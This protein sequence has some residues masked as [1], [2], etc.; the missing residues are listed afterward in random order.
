ALIRVVNLFESFETGDLQ[1]KLTAI[2]NKLESVNTYADQARQEFHRQ[3]AI[4]KG[5]LRAWKADLIPLVQMIL[6][7]ELHEGESFYTQDL[8]QMLEYLKF[9]ML[10]DS[11]TVDGSTV[12]LTGPSAGAN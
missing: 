5:T 10:R 9:C 8:Q 4:L 11:E 3:E 1:T 12:N 7:Q 2:Y 6:A